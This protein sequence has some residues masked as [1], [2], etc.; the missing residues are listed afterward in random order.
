MG[1]CIQDN[2]LIIDDSDIISL[3]DIY[4]S[5]QVFRWFDLKNEKYAIV[6]FDK[7]CVA[8]R[9]DRTIILKD[10]ENNYDYWINYFNLNTNYEKEIKD[11]LF[12]LNDPFLNKAVKYSPGMR[13]LKQE[14]FETIISFIIS[15]NNNI[16][17]IKKN[18]EDICKI[19]DDPIVKLDKNT[20][21]RFPSPEELSKFSLN[22]L[23]S[24]KLGYRASYVKS[25]ADLI[26]HGEFDIEKLKLMSTEDAK[27]YLCN[28]TGVGPK[29]ADCI[30]LFSM[31]RYDVF[32]VDTWVKK[33]MHNHYGTDLKASVK[34]LRSEG[35]MRF[36]NLCGVAQQY[37]FYYERAE[38]SATFTPDND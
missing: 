5:G 26:A 18:I 27:K 10:N 38:S 35:Q 6:S 14:I 2:N 23:N 16:L 8:E 22:E 15:A 37:L 3:R 17:R 13:I 4:Y 7:S 30:L 29:V 25:T 31:S 32:P 20:Y 33:I 12:S 36:G 1:F 24:I 19:L 34:S 9:K 28:L 21:L 11:K